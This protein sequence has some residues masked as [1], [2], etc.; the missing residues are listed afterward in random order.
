MVK[1]SA[2]VIKKDELLGAEGIT[3]EFYDKQV[4]GLGKWIDA[5]EKDIIQWGWFVFK[6][7]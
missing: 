2:L 4:N 6:K 5:G 3:Q 1:Y 7:E